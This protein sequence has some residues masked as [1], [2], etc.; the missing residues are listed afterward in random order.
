MNDGK[1]LPEW[2]KLPSQWIE[3]KGLRKFRWSGGEG[4]DFQA[5]LMLLTVIVNHADVATGICRLTYDRLCEATSLSRAK[6]ARGLSVLSDS[7]LIERQDRSSFRVID[8]NVRS[9]WAKLP[10]R[11]LYQGRQ[12]TPFTNFTL[13]RRAELDALKLYF[14]LACRR[15]EKM[16]MALISYDKIEEYSGVTRE[17]IKRD[18]TVL[19]AN[20]LVHVEHVP[21]AINRMGVANAYRL[22]H[23][24]PR[25]HMGTWGRGIDAAELEFEN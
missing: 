7:K 8:H 25:Q 19:G 23:L 1:N 14:L 2:T 22:V 11:G 13:R 18:L 20:G 17:H 6:V 3:Q 9:G 12:I 21:T 24:K 15:S 4:A 16:N 10:A 5:A